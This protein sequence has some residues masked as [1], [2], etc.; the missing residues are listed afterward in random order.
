[1]RIV[2]NCHVQLSRS[3]VVSSRPQYTALRWRKVP[4]R[5]SAENGIPF[6]DET[7]AESV[8][9][10]HTECNTGRR[11]CSSYGYIRSVSHAICANTK[12]QKKLNTLWKQREAVAYDACG[13]LGPRPRAP[14]RRPARRVLP[15]PLGELHLHFR[16]ALAVVLVAVGLDTSS[17]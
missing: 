16:Q 10:G 5:A 1:M 11:E 8:G 12:V 4:V 13:E 7:R 3:K 14:H 17:A 15:V 9:E 2:Y 6:V